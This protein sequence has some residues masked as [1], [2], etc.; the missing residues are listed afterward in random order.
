MLLAGAV[1]LL[2][3]LL[4]GVTLTILWNWLI[5]PAFGLPAFPLLTAIWISLVALVLKTNM[6]HDE[7]LPGDDLSIKGVVIG[8]LIL[9]AS[10]FILFSVGVWSL[11]GSLAPILHLP[12]ISSAHVIGIGIIL[13]FLFDQSP[14]YSRE[15]RDDVNPS[16]NSILF[17]LIKPTL[18]VSIGGIV[19]LFL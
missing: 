10:I 4:N 18:A 3:L 1:N 13:G 14:L 12:S 17:R 6:T 19:C 11:W 5:V 9:P 16:R 2:S 15:I 7:K 8:M